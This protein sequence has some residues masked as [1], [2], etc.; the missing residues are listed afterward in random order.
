[1]LDFDLETRSLSY[2]F[3]PYLSCSKRMEL[4]LIFYLLMFC[5]NKTLQSDVAFVKLIEIVMKYGMRLFQFFAYRTPF[6]ANC[7]SLEV[8]P[9]LCINCAYGTCENN[10]FISWFQMYNYCNMFHISHIRLSS[11]FANHFQDKTR[12]TVQLSATMQCI[13]LKQSCSRWLM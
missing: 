1:M 8:N 13:C 12:N 4:I 11:N 5:G 2:F 10:Y 3:T 6:C 7:N 9:A